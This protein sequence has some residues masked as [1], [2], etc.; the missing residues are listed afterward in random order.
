MSVYRRLLAVVVI[1]ALLFALNATPSGLAARPSDSG[2][3]YAVVNIDRVGHERL[4]ALKALPSL[5]WWVELDDQL[6]VC[7]DR[8]MLAAL[9]GRYAY[10]TLDGPLNP[11]E[12]SVVYR[13][14]GEEAD[15]PGVRVLARG[16]HAS[17]IHG[18]RSRAPEHGGAPD[19]N[20]PHDVH[21]T[22]A[23]FV[24]NAVIARQAANNPPRATAD[25]DVS[26]QSLVDSVNGN[27]W[28]ADVGTLGGWN[29]F[30][31]NAGVLAARDWLVGQFQTLPGLT[32]TTQAFSVGQTTAYNV[33]ATLQ[34]TTRPN[35]W[36][37][38]GAHYDATSQNPSSAAP[39]CEDNASGTAGVLEMARIFTAHPPEATVIF[40]CYS[41]EEQG[42]YG[43]EFHASQLVASGDNTK[44]RAHL[45]MDMIGYTGD[46]D[47]DCLLE[48]GA[49]GQF[50]ID[51]YAAA[52]A[53]YTTLRIVTSL[54]PFGS[55]HVPYINR[56][57]PSL[58]TIENDWN[59]YPHYHRTT[60]TIANISIDMGA[61]ILRMNVGAL[62]QM[63][64]DPPA[65]RGLDSPGVY[66]P[67]SSTFFLRNS[68]S[69]GPADMAF[70]FGPAGSGWQP[71]AGDWN[72]DGV[73]TI[74]LY[75]P[76]IS[77]FFLRNTNTPGVADTVVGFGPAGSGWTPLAGD[78][79][80]NGS[81]TIGLYSSSTGTFFLKNSNTPGPADVIASYGPRGALPVTG[82][83]DGNGTDT[84]GVFVAS[85]SV[86]FVRNS[87]SPGPA[88]LSYS[89]GPAGAGWTPVAGDWNGDNASTPGL[90]DPVAGAWFERN[91]N[92][93]GNAAVTFTYGPRPGSLPIRGDWDNR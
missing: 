57:M 52:A 19:H 14:H 80:G 92:S 5:E 47:L 48:T 25:F 33:V 3:V 76:V 31:R 41:G 2:K 56:G 11:K 21:A 72:A 37:I 53:Q 15:E 28:H 38:V 39:G 12:L 75:D 58:L 51:A 46:S 85:T 74:G 59:S 20:G 1:G 30:T 69:P 62:A 27:R 7:G 32:V 35:D 66:I 87:S 40:I 88:D 26:I 4:T 29:R 34:G 9:A 93:Q 82:D 44:V 86:W 68:N 43:S 17:V 54:N 50:L 84:V 67:S 23:P 36:Y 79:D 6:L 90:Y 91:S 73:D 61:Q 42:L 83:W 89:F 70:R 18:S 13:L 10:R 22:A 71:V 63:I 24:P 65:G 78:W 77:T 49:I 60:D 81:D 16:G 8:A 64:G 45:N 55:D